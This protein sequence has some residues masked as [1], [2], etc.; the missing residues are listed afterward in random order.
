MKRLGPS[1]SEALELIYREFRTIGVTEGQ[2]L[3]Q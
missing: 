1:S 3:P 2:D